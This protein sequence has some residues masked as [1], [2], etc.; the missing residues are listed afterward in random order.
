ML[1]FEKLDVF[2]A[3]LEF[4]GAA[5]GTGARGELK[6]QLERA[7]SSVVLNIAE[8]AGR[9]QWKDKRRFYE[10]ARGS[11]ME[12]AAVLM[13]AGEVEPRARELAERVVAMLTRLCS[14]T[15]R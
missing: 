13:M 3:A 11:A 14:K 5:M 7:T 6:D 15:A 12:S 10:I 4:R 9:W 2:Q 1:S 8:G